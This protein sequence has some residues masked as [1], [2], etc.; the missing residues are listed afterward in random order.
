MVLVI[1]APMARS[2]IE[3]AVLASIVWA[4]GGQCR[5][6]LAEVSR[7]FVLE[8]I[9]RAL[10]RWASPAA[11]TVREPSGMLPRHRSGARCTEASSRQSGTTHPFGMKSTANVIRQ[12]KSMMSAF[13]QPPTPRVHLGLAMIPVR[14]ALVAGTKSDD[15]DLLSLARL[16]PSLEARNIRN[17]EQITELNLDLTGVKDDEMS[18]VA[19]AVNLETLSL[20]STRITDSGLRRIANL[21]SLMVLDLSDTEV[22]DASLLALKSLKNMVVLRLS[23]TNVGPGVRSWLQ[24]C[25]QL[26]YLSLDGTHVEDRDLTALRDCKQL[27]GL[28]LGQTKLSGEFLEHCKALADLEFLDLAGVSSLSNLSR[29]G[30]LR[31]LVILNL[32]KV[33]VRDEDLRGIS[34]LSQLTRLNL[35]R[36]RISDTGVLELLKLRALKAI[37]FA[38]T[39]LSDKGAEILLQFNHLQFVDLSGTYVSEA[40][41]EK[42]KRRFRDLELLFDHPP[43]NRLPLVRRHPARPQGTI[44]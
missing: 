40:M 17:V 1:Q 22:T 4:G 5:P 15:P 31:H 38:D 28:F 34:S 39:A 3:I 18:A 41:R 33:D 13:A 10:G 32:A 37:Y 43:A 24:Q 12:R 35:S 11:S 16:D 27:H 21:K 42:L 19:R 44:G 30:E 25:T 14:S 29:L 8:L 7:R 2:S 6:E 26:W 9:G 36:A 20:A 23:R